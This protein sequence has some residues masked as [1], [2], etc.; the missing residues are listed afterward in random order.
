MWRDLWT[1]TLKPLPAARN[2]AI[3]VS[4]EALN[5]ERSRNNWSALSLTRK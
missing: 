3:P 2:Q 4:K 1:L 5:S